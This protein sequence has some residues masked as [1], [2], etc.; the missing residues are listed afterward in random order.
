MDEQEQITVVASP[1]DKAAGEQGFRRLWRD[2][3]GDSHA[4]EDFYFAQ[5][6][7]NNAVY[8]AGDKG[9]LH[10]NPYP[11]MV[12]GKEQALFYIVG[13]ATEEASR[14]QGV[15]RRL[16]NRALRD[17]HDGK[18][19]FTYLMPA[20]IRYYRPFGFVPISGKR[21]KNIDREP[22]RSLIEY[23]YVAYSEIV[24]GAFGSAA[25]G[26]KNGAGQLLFAAAESILKE[27]CRIYAKHDAEYFELL[28]QEKKCNGG[29]IVFVFQG[30]MSPDALCGFFAYCREEEKACVEQAVFRQEFS[31]EQVEQILS[32]YGEFPNKIRLTMRFPF[33]VRITDMESCLRLFP[34]EAETILMGK[35]VRIR[36]EEI[37]GNNGIYFMET[38]DGKRLAGRRPIEGSEG[39]LAPCDSEMAIAEFT[40]LLFR[41]IHTD[42]IYFAEVV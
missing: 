8:A 4:Y 6:Y 2:C 25:D 37:P 24:S 28:Y 16:L 39:E 14:R 3:F 30:E 31:A 19:P 18:I 7:R 9:M 21:E 5:V 22:E 26:E 15:M 13:V 1:E 41:E 35:K 17:M 40:R 20:D 23:R 11:V 38:A 10:L 36:D 12:D 32:G 29:D 27:S 34:A 33:M 42:K